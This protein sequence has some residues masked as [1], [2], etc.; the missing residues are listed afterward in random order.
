MHI[1]QYAH[2]LAHFSHS[3]CSAIANLTISCVLPNIQFQSSVALQHVKIII[4]VY[5]RTEVHVR[6]V[7]QFS[8]FKSNI[9]PS[10]KPNR[11]DCAH[12]PGS[13][14][15]SFWCI[16]VAD[17]VRGLS[18]EEAAGIGWYKSGN[19]GRLHDW[20]TS[21]M[22]H[23]RQGKVILYGMYW[24]N[25]WCKSPWNHSSNAFFFFI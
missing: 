20:C 10:I 5:K 12:S 14:A 6:N 17:V 8:V 25:W 7:S 19:V 1:T 11:R 22:L 21:T 4:G 3:A 13:S 18:G 24:N 9:Q 16:A 23:S 15:R 2:E